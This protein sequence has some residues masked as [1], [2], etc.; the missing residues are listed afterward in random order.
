MIT[1]RLTRELVADCAHQGECLP[2]V[3]AWA[4]RLRWLRKLEPESLRRYLKEFG[5]WDVE[6]LADHAANMERFLWI[7]AGDA[8]EAAAQGETSPYVRT[9][10]VNAL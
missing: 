7:A 9:Y 6:E 4:P 3:R 5:A 1:I 8:K 2:D 10:E